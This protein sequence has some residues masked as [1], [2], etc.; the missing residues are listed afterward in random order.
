[1]HFGVVR[2][3]GR[4]DVLQHGGL[5]SLRRRDD[6]AALAL[7]DGSGEVDNARGHIV[8]PVLHRQALVGEHRREVGELH[9]VA[10][11]FR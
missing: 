5:A 9:P 3:D 7:S 4:R 8:L 2:R 6:E 11:A 10:K 1:M